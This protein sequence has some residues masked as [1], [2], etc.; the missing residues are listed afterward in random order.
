LRLP[1]VAMTCGACSENPQDP[2]DSIKQAVQ[3]QRGFLT[4][5]DDLEAT[6]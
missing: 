4:Q 5:C 1:G 6:E 3:N 2:E